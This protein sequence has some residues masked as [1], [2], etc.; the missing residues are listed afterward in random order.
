M[1]RWAL[2]MRRTFNNGDISPT[3]YKNIVEA[4]KSQIDSW[5]SSHTGSDLIQKPVFIAPD[6][7]DPD[8]TWLDGITTAGAWGDIYRVGTALLF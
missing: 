8:P 7:Y 1:I 4:L 2:I 3:K 6:N 5:N